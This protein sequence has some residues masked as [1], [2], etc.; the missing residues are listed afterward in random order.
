MAAGRQAEAQ[1]QPSL[2]PRGRVVGILFGRAG[3][4]EVPGKN[5]KE[6]LGRPSLHYPLMAARA[7]GIVE[8]LYVSTD[9]PA[10]LELAK[11]FDVIPIQRPAHLA[12]NSAL[13]EETIAHAFE[14]VER[15]TRFPIE[16]Y[17]ILLCNAVTVLP[18]RIRQ[19]YEMLSR[20]PQVDSVTTVAKWNMF[21]P[22]RAWKLDRAGENRLD[23][24]V[25][26]DLLQ[27]TVTMSC[28][29]DQSTD[30]FFC[31]HSFTLTRRATLARLREHPGPFRWMGTRIRAIEQM[32]GTGDVD[33]AW[34]LPVVEWWLRQQGF[35]EERV[36]YQIA[37]PGNV[38][39]SR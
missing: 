7:S 26:L 2:S 14:V 1:R 28:D 30:C 32:P 10:I 25:P 4:V 9:S 37:E 33:V 17:L 29:R 13:L 6:I 24:Y 18:L 11:P 19:A 8:E 22:V 5:I 12:T 23:H 27:R 16:S 3:S 35:T 39:I 36:P 15:M 31:D 34:Q 21:S 20:D 38:S